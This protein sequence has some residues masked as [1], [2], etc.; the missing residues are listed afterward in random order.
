MAAALDSVLSDRSQ[1]CRESHSLGYFDRK[2][3]RRDHRYYCSP[4]MA[5]TDMDFVCR[6]VFHI[7][8]SVSIFSPIDDGSH[9]ELIVYPC[10]GVRPLSSNIFKDLLRNSLTDQSLYCLCGLH[11]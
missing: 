5:I 11:R 3:R 7:F 9:D 1:V 4:D 8:K 10:S 2:C 6:F